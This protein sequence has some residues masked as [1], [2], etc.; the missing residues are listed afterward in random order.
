MTKAELIEKMATD[1][2]YYKGS[3]RQGLRFISGGN[4]RWAKETW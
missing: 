2:E 1:A 4:K 3:G